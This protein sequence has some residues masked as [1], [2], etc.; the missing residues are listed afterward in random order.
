MAEESKKTNT[1]MAIVAYFIFFLPLLTDDKNDPFVK[2][3]VKQSLVLVICYVLISV[4][5]MVPLVGWFA[6]PIL[7]VVVFVFWIM[8]ILNAAAGKQVPVPVVGH[9]GEK[10]NF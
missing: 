4:L 8:G 7:Y 2:Y 6:A 5:F 3:H 9:Y 10:F 1:G